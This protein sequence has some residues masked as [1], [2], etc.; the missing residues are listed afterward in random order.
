MKFP[1]NVTKRYGELMPTIT[2]G[3]Y[4]RPISLKGLVDTGS[5]FTVLT[6]AGMAL[7]K[8]RILPRRVPKE[9]YN[10]VLAGYEFKR[11]LMDSLPICLKTGSKKGAVFDM[12]DV[13]VLTPSKKVDIKK[14]H[15]DFGQVDIILGCDFIKTFNLS[16]YFD[17]SKKAAYLLSPD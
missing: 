14:L 5:P 9:H 17:P 6:P 4:G 1:I 2:V 8:I 15:K 12:P 10:I 7:L 16:L 11:N 3:V 13:G